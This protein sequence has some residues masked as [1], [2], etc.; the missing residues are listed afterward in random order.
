MHWLSQ[1][2]MT[3]CVCVCVT[4]CLVWKRMIPSSTFDRCATQNWEVVMTAWLPANLKK[5][6]NHCSSM[7]CMKPELRSV[8]EQFFFLSCNLFLLVS[9]SCLRS[10]HKFSQS[11]SR[12]T[13][14]KIYTLLRKEK[15]GQKETNKEISAEFVWHLQHKH[16]MK[17]L[18]LRKDSPHLLLSET[19]Q[20][21][22]L[23]IS[24]E[25]HQHY[26][27]SDSIIFFPIPIIT[28]QIPL[29]L[30]NQWHFTSSMW[31]DNVGGALSR[32][33]HLSET[34]EQ[35]PEGSPSARSGAG[36]VQRCGWEE[37]AGVCGARVKMGG[38][39]SR[40]KGS[41]RSSSKSHANSVT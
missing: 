36:E 15:K 24:P 31:G 22:S 12:K 19:G 8:L 17:G 18:N 21:R 37:H 38:T 25:P 1:G 5:I 30:S 32:K 34:E 39:V 41:T 16:I 23:K 3:A 29:D 26:H 7:L 40:R 20:A 28:S 6:W 14:A 9:K 2:S 13:V 11:K 27:F 33:T 35:K 4:L 10:P